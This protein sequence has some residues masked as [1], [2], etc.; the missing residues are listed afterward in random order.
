MP[1]SNQIKDF[2]KFEELV[3]QG[4]DI[5]KAVRIANSGKEYPATEVSPKSEPEPQKAGNRYPNPA[6]QKE[7]T[8][9]LK[10]DH[11]G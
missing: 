2:K 1:S 5:A 11:Y 3:E 7:V 4:M 8:K 6:F 9:P 10:P